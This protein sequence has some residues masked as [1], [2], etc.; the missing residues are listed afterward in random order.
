MVR[1]LVGAGVGLTILAMRPFTDISYGGD[2]LCALPLEPGLPGF[3]LLSGWVAD[4]PRRPVTAFQE[5]LHDWMHGPE[6][7]RLTIAGA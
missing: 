7:R 3:Q 6:A 4:R 1:G 2:T 5:A